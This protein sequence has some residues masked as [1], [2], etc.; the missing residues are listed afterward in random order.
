MAT[1]KAKATDREAGGDTYSFYDGRAILKKRMYGNAPS[2][3]RVLED[4]TLS[5][6]I[7]SVTRCTGNLDKSKALIPWAVGLVGSHIT[8]FIESAKAMHFSKEEIAILVAEAILAPEQAKVAGADAGNLIHDYAHEFAAMKIAGKKGT[9]S[10]RHLDETN[11]VHA[12]A[13]NGISAFLDWFNSNDVEF[14]EMEKMV[15]YNS[16]LSGDSTA[17][18]PVVE[19]YGYIDLVA[20]VNGKVAVTDYKS[21]K[22]V[23]NEQR[24]QVAGLRKAYGFGLSELGLIVNFHKET[25]ELITKEMNDEESMADLSAFMGLHT[26]ELRQRVLLKEY[27]ASKK[28]AV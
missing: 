26:V 10:L 4:G 8:S 23:Y 18:E 19:W 27:Q 20:R 14:L 9:P 17:S 2:F 25:A 13:L 3:R 6:T 16:F 28:Q 7:L 1:K 12:R 15:Y 21:A 11:E 22:G 5:D 24:Y